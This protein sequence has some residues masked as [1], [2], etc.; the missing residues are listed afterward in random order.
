MWQKAVAVAKTALDEKSAVGKTA[1]IVG[2]L[3][4]LEASMSDGSPPD[5]NR[6]KALAQFNDIFN[7]M[8]CGQGQSEQG[9]EL[10]K[11]LADARDSLI[12]KAPKLH[13]VQPGF[14]EF[15]GQQWL[16]NSSNFQLVGMS[17]SV[18]LNFHKVLDAGTPP[19]VQ[20][21]NTTAKTWGW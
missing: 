8:K 21:R 10:L 17:A 1:E 11:Q 12:I 4:K 7:L 13:E 6:W 3:K 15:L 18:K 5:V 20:Q 9:D 19:P 16:D 2:S 14:E